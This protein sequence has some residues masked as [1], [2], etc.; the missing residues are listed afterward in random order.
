MTTA[1]IAGEFERAE[2]AASFVLART[3][4]R[5]SVALVL[6][7]GLGAMA[8]SLTDAVRLPYA[9]IPGFPQPTAEGH[10]GQLVIGR[11]ATADRRAA[12]G[13]PVA[14]MQGRVHFYEGLPLRQLVFPIR[15]FGR[16]GIRSVVLTNAAGGIS[17]KLEPGCLVVLEDHINLQGANP[18][19]GPNDE[20]FGPRFPDLQ[21]AYDAAFRE[22]A[23]AAG[24]R[25]GVPITSGVYAAMT[26]PSYESPAEIRFLRTIGADVVGMSTVAE[27]IAARHQGMKV[28][29]I[30]CVTNLA[31]GI[32]QA[33]ITHDEVI[34]MGRRVRAG[35]SALLASVIPVIAR[36]QKIQG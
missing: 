17:E 5:P 23:L 33:P 4:L 11:L 13:V 2:Q 3:A 24:K 32:Q 25:L 6:G 19:I 12:E 10:A 26:G 34:A 18:L 27:V 15:V 30:S 1:A 7:S 9:A 36:D 28:L 14:A 31:A 16:M 35:F 22:L 29:A 20:R 21:N 8:D